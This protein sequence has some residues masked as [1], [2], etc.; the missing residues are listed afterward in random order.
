MTEKTFCS[1]CQRAPGT[2]HLR[3]AGC[4]NGA[5]YKYV[6]QTEFTELLIEAGEIPSGLS[7]DEFRHRSNGQQLRSKDG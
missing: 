4:A 3:F 1:R 7:A 5:P 2:E 6:T